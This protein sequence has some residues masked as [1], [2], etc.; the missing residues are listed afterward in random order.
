ML[1]VSIRNKRRQGKDE[2][3]NEVCIDRKAG[4]HRHNKRI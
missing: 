4:Q 1:N 2:W 3:F